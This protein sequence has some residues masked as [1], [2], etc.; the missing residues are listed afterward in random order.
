MTDQD[1]PIQTDTNDSI[2]KID[3]STEPE[4]LGVELSE[5]LKKDP[6]VIDEIVAP[7]QAA[8]TTES[9]EPAAPV[10]P[11]TPSEPVIEQKDYDV[12][13]S[14]P[15]TTPPVPK[16]EFSMPEQSQQVEEVVDSYVSNPAIVNSS[17]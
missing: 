14:A 16:K 9:V 2:E 3:S 4:L 5:E 10:Q 17:R 12:E 6:T 8:E 13:I 15:D 11:E 7:P 1:Q